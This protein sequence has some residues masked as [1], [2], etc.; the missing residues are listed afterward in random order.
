MHDHLGDTLAGQ[1]KL[2]EAVAEWELALKEWQSS[3]PSDQ[4]PEEAARIRA[5]LESARMRLAR[6]NNQ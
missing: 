1:S 3:S 5:K 4:D 2:R 6:E